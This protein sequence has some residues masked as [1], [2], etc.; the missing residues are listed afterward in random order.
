MSER[1]QQSWFVPLRVRFRSP[2]EQAQ[3]ERDHILQSTLGD[4]QTLPPPIADVATG[5][6]I[7][8]QR[9]TRQIK[10]LLRL[11]NIMRADLGL[12]EVLQQIVASASMCTGF[13]I[14][15]VHLI[16]DG[17]DFLSPFAFAGMSEE[18]INILR[19]V[20]RPVEQVLRLMRPEFRISQSYFISH[21]Y[22]QDFADIVSVINKTVEDY[23]SGGWH[24]DDALIVPL[25]S[26]RKKKLLGFLSL[27]DPE[28][29]KVPTMESIEVAELFANQAA[30][31][32][33]NARIFQE[34]EAEVQ[35][36]D[37]AIATLLGDLERI[38]RGD[39]RARIQSTHEKLQPIGEAIN[40]MVEEFSGILGNVQTVTQ[41]VDKH[42]RDVQHSS[43]LL[44]RDASQQE[45]QVQHISRAIDEI[46]G[47][48]TQL[49]A[50]ASELS[51]VVLE[52]VEVTL[53]GQSAVDRAVEGMSQVRGAT[54]LSA[55]IMKRLGESGQEINETI[56]AIT[57]LTT[58]MN[59]VALN[60]AIEATRAGE[61]GHGFVVIAQEIR[62]LAL[63]SSEAAKK[64][65]SH[66]RAIQRETTAISQSVE[67]NTLEAV[68]QTELVT[69]TGVA[70]DAI[71]VVTEQM[72]G[73]VQGICMAADNQA[74]SSQLVV[75]AVEQI[76]QMTSEITLHM[77]N[78]QQSLAQLVELTNS[79]S[80]RMAVFRINE[81]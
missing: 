31:A 43:D 44:V 57:D 5:S 60:A 24:P 23:E 12:S 73:L 21:E 65:A 50:S 3:W 78:M 35:V 49:S 41:A 13:R 64:V 71:S 59:L 7:E 2:A 52:A 55:R 6:D 10:E 74:Q 45:R 67:H 40:Q 79:L 17:D 66:I 39:L 63:N 32:I 29:G 16:E 48:M 62:T 4:S 27:D 34:K 26:P 33:D 19:S 38:Q 53:D 76:A 77:R 80:S 42:A 58:R 70:F 30:I 37:K 81:R 14:L 8:A 72:A 51:R 56:L 28:D 69:Q 46:A 20:R 75:S 47:T 15:V 1:R 18:N 36:Q 61:Q 22:I 9:H 54:T 11:S 68:K 25:F